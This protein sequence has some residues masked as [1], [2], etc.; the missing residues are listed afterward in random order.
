MADGLVLRRG[1]IEDVVIIGGLIGIQVVYAGNTMLMNYLMALGLSSS[2]F[3][4][5]S[6]IA[7]FL[8]LSPLAYIYERGKWPTKF[9]FRLIIQLVFIAFG[10]VY[11][12]QS[13]FLKG[14][15]LTSPAMATAMPN[16]A[17]GLIFLIAWTLR[18]ERVKLSCVY[19]KV[20]ILGTLLSVAG[21]VTMSVIHSSAATPTS[22]AD[23]IATPTIDPSEII[24]DKQRIIGCLYLMA[25]VFVLSSSVVLQ[26]TTLVDF[27]A[28]VS[29]CAITSL[30][31][32]FITAA[33][34]LFQDHKLELGLPVLSVSVVI[35]YSFLAGAVGGACVSF[36]GWAIK[37]RGPVFV[38]IFNPVSTVCSIVLSVATL[39]ETISLGSLGGMFLMFTGL[40]FVLWA[41]GKEGYGDEDGFATEFDT[42]KP[43]LS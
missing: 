34:Q 35:G 19:S 43:L 22:E 36:N 10:G 29:M 2:T 9:S 28:P 20:K 4:I 23:F 27:P 39:G 13:L 24:F 7:T 42:E 41:K 32:V 33:V 16:L 3:V 5:F 26:A 37:K 18:L 30:I 6:S 38:S 15:T 8:L 1:M 21:A 31:G 11:L 12:F 14:I 25:A 40:Y 17:P